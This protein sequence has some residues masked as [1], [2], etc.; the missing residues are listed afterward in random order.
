MM[1]RPQI[2]RALAGLE[3]LEALSAELAPRRAPPASKGVIELVEVA[4][5]VFAA[6]SRPRRAESGNEPSLSAR[7]RAALRVADE[8]AARTKKQE[9][10]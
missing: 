9:L 6:P 1:K 7:V 3:A 4:P 10:L 2:D 5:G 8:L